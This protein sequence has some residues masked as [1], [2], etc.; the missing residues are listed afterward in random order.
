MAIAVVEVDRVPVG[1]GRPGEISRK[2]Q[3]RY[4]DAITG[5]VPEYADWL[6]PV[7]SNAAARA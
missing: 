7:Y 2:L 6:T 3:Q 4:F 1:D 5:R